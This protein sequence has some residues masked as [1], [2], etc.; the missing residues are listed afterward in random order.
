MART[1]F[2][3]IWHAHVIRELGNGWALLHV[4]RH[5]LHDLSGP[6]TPPP[7]AR[8][9]VPFGTV[10]FTPPSSRGDRE[11][12]PKELFDSHQGAP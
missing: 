11:R 5:L 10:A 9:Q 1:L 12:L 6:G 7:H 4:D 3:K 8:P 2:A